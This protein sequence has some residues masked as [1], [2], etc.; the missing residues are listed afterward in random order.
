M[1]HF[2]TY[3]TFLKSH[4]RASCGVTFLLLL[5]V[6]R[7]ASVA[8]RKPGITTALEIIEQVISGAK[9][10]TAREVTDVEKGRG[11]HS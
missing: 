8:W 7:L 4:L 10:C 2:S 11:Q 6:E 3:F 1:H 9:D 5:V